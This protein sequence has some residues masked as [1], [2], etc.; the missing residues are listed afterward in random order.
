MGKNHFSFCPFCHSNKISKVLEAKDFLVSNN[1]YEIWH[2]NNCSFRFTQDVPTL[3]EIGNYYKSENYISHS[4][5][6]KGIINNLYHI[7]RKF[8]LHIKYRHIKKRYNKKSGFLLDIGAGTGYFV[9]FMTKRGYK[10]EGIEVDPEARKIAEKNFGIKLLEANDI[11]KLP[12]EKYDI[13]TMWHVLEH[14][15]DLEGYIK[16]IKYSLK[17]DGLFVCALPNYTSFDCDYYKENWAAYDV[18]RHLWH[19]SPY[20]FQ[21]FAAMYEFEIIETKSMPLDAIYISILSEK[22]KGR[23]AIF[24]FINGSIFFIKSLLN[25][26]KASSIIYFMKKI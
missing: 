12:K 16:R 11:Y 13:I 10:T 20:F 19:F 2:C 6:S 5:T 25:K 7:A 24:G 3:E 18:P 22:I 8:M 17:K 4:D 23:N 14:I 15:H 26:N 1:S 21:Q 9:D